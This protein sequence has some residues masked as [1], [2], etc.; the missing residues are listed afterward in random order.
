MAVYM[1]ISLKLRYVPRHSEV[2]HSM[3]FGRVLNNPNEALQA[4]W[5]GLGAK[6]LRR[7]A[8]LIRGMPARKTVWKA[9]DRAHEPVVTARNILFCEL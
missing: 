6:C 8:R 7:T 2:T 4:R 9:C 3:R 1:S 5:A